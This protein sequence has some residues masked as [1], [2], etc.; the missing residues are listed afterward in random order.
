MN[1][2]TA[3]RQLYLSKELDDWL[4]KRADE[5]GRKVNAIILE[6][7]SNYIRNRS[8]NENKFDKEFENKVIDII[9]EYNSKHDIQNSGELR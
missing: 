1:K 5:S 8:T 9:K 3:R 6:A 7:L 2:N 4:V